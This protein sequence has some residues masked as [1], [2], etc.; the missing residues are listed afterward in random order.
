MAGKVI[1]VT[2]GSRGIGAATAKLAGRQGY[3]VCVNY[4]SN[5]DAAEAVADEIR[6]AGG[7]AITVAGDVAREE[8]IVRLFATV[9]Q[10]LGPV[11]ALVNNAGIL[12]HQSRLDDMS[13]ER[14]NRVLVANIT[15][16]LLCAR[17]AVKRMSTRHGGKGGAIVNLSSMAA[18]LGGPGE[19][20]DYA[21]SKGAIDAFTIGLAKE[22]AAE[23]IRV[24]AVRP[25]LI[26]TD[27]HASGGEAGRVDRLKDAVPMKR[28]GTAEEVANAILWLLSDESSYATGTFIDV[29]GGR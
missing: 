16:S 3:A 4:V 28:G 9:D 24:N 13:A 14:I 26:Y 25:G 8:D 19:Y 22:V 21:A 15:G 1:V 17:E 2:G 23:G 11:T 6:Q 5:R 12:G 27:I 10:E 29:S 7:R 20:V 18:K